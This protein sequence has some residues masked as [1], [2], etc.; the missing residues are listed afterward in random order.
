MKVNPTLLNTALRVTVE[1]LC[2]HV[3]DLAT[4]VA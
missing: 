3:C 4:L 1:T 2:E